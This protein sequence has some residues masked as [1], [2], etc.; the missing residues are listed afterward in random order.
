MWVWN[1]NIFRFSKSPP[2][3]DK[4]K[5][6]GFFC[7]TLCFPGNH[8]LVSYIE[9]HSL[10][11]FSAL[12]EGL[13]ILQA[14]LSKKLNPRLLFPAHV[15][16]WPVSWRRRAMSLP[17]AG[18][19][20]ITLHVSLHN[21]SCLTAPRQKTSYCRPGLKILQIIHAMNSLLFL[22]KKILLSFWTWSLS[23]YSTLTLVTVDRVVARR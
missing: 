14:F 8:S 23:G 4:L 15:V 18:Q 16:A 17:A 10:D 19:R 12:Q 9:I 21:K 20:S 13:Y 7:G 11:Y 1:Q 6:M 5:M 22:R 2:D 3:M